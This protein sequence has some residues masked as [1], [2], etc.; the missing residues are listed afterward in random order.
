MGSHRE[1]NGS[2]LRGTE[3]LRSY[4]S[5]SYPQGGNRMKTITVFVLGLMV[6]TCVSCIEYS[7]KGVVIAKKFEQSQTTAYT[8]TVMEA[9][10]IREVSVNA[11]LWKLASCGDSLFVSENNEIKLQKR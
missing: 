7:I 1:R 4:G 2:I 6:F 11:R 5:Y 10:H 3:M 9:V 8:L